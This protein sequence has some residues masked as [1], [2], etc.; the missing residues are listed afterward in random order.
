MKFPENT[1]QNKLDIWYGAMLAIGVI[2]LLPAM[3][4]IM[5]VVKAFVITTLWHWYIVPFF[6]LP[7]LPLAISFGISL[8]ISY[9][10]PE[11]ENNKD[12]TLGQKLAYMI[13]FPA[14]VL[15][16]GWIGTFFI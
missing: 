14:T 2:M 8:L 10:I 9:L 16:F 4:F 13:L 11:S 1:K 15:L 7:E 6:H 12:W 5:S 3:I